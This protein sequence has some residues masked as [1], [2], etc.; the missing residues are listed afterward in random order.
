[1]GNTIR[2]TFFSHSLMNSYIIL[3]L[4]LFLISIYCVLIPLNRLRVEYGFSI[5]EKKESK[6]KKKQIITFLSGPEQ[7]G[8]NLRKIKLFLMKEVLISILPLLTVILI[9]LYLGRPDDISYTFTNL[10][11][12]LILYAVWLFHNIFSSIKFRNMITPYIPSMQ[13]KLLDKIHHPK[14]LFAMLNFSNISRS[15]INSLSKMD[16]PDYVEHRDL[17]IKPMNLIDTSKKVDSAAILE[18]LTAIGGKVVDTV[19]NLAIEGKK[20]T[21]SGLSLA[22]EQINAYVSKRVET[23]TNQENRWVSSLIQIINVIVPVLFIYI[24]SIIW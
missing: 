6:K 2:E 12:I 16:I 15:K 18:N 13:K 7:S 17:D 23:W 19:T 9:R 1:M 10:V 20:L 22:D 24:F 4:F 8:K 3:A 11:L 5:K 21:K 14:Y